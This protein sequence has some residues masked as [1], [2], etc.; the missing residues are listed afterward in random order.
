MSA[1]LCNGTSGT[2]GYPPRVSIGVRNTIIILGIAALAVVWERAFS[3]AVSSVSQIISVLFVV[4]I[5]AAGVQY[6][7]RNQLAWLVLRPWQ[8]VAVVLSALAIAF[9][10]IAGYPLLADRITPLGYLALIAALVLLIWW[11]IRDS[12]KL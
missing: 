5:L 12:R 3:V 10:V 8:R 6:F 7:R 9:L 4:A 11:I 1:H 2:R